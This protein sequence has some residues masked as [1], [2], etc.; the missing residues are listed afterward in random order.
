MEGM[1]LIVKTVTRLLKGFILLYGVYITL[2]SHLSPG[3]GFAGGVIAACAFILIILA[4]GKRSG[5]KTLSENTARVLG[6]VGGLIFLVTGVG[7]MFVAGIFLKNFIPTGFGARFRLFSA[8]TIPLCNIGV[9]LI[10]AMSLFLVFSV[11]SSIH[12][13]VKDNKRKMIKRGEDNT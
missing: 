2:Y 10:V 1:S 3:D 12:V 7:G 9:A 4:E 8:G 6:S 5:M 13:E 11:F